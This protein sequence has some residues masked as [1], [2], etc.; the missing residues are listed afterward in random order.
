MSRT[1]CAVDLKDDSPRARIFVSLQAVTYTLWM[2]YFV[3]EAGKYT[4][5]L[6]SWC[7]RLGQSMFIT[8]ASNKINTVFDYIIPKGMSR[9]PVLVPVHSRYLAI[10]IDMGDGSC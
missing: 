9:R 10:D 1:H 7:S 5:A 2:P 4:G 8:V 6:S 3:T